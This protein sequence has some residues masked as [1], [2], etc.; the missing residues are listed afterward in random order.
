M[1]DTTAK[2]MRAIATNAVR[3]GWAIF[4]LRP[5]AKVPL[6]RKA[7]G[8]RGVYDGTHDVATVDAWW[9][10]WPDANIGVSCGPA[11]EWSGCWVLDVD[12]HHGGTVTLSALVTAHGPLPKTRVVRTASGGQ[13]WFFRWPKLEEGRTLRNAVGVRGR[14]GERLAGLDVRAAGG[15]V[16]GAGSVAESKVTGS[17]MPYT[18]EV[19]APLADAPEWLLA[20]VAPVPLRA[21]LPP[22]VPRPAV[23]GDELFRRRVAWCRSSLDTCCRNL[24]GLAEGGRNDATNRALMA[25]AGYA[26][27]GYLGSDEVK[28]A[29]RAAA[30]ASG[31]SSREV[32]VIFRG[33]GAWDKGYAT[34]R[35]PELEDRPEYGRPWAPNGGAWQDAPP[36]SD[37]DAP[38]D[39]GEERQEEGGS[40]EGGDESSPSSR[41]D[42]FGP[43]RALIREVY[44]IV[45]RDDT[46][47][48][49]RQQAARTL[50]ESTDAL[51]ALAYRFPGE[52]ESA[53]AALATG[54]GF[55]EHMQRIASAVRKLVEERRKA[56]AAA[57]RTNRQQQD[58]K[59]QGAR[60]GFLVRCDPTVMVRLD[61][62][63][64]MVDGVPE[65]GDPKPTLSNAVLILTDD[66]ACRDRIRFNAFTQLVEIDGVEK[67]DDLDTHVAIALDRAYGLVLP[68]DRVREALS[69]VARKNTYDPLID[70]LDG[71]VW[72]GVNRIGAVF[73]DYF[74]IATPRTV[75]ADG[76]MV[77]DPEL[78]AAIER[79]FF[80]G[81]V[82]RAFK[83]GCKLDTMPVFVGLGG[84][85]KS[86]A[87]AALCPRPEWFSDTPIDLRDK[88][89][90][91]ALDGIWIYEQ[92]ELD[93]LNSGS[94]NRA[95]GFM[96]SAFD[97]YRRPYD[98]TPQRHARRTAMC[99]STNEREF[100]KD[101]RFHP[102]DVRDDGVMNPEGVA[103]LRDQLW[104]EAVAMY[105]SGVAWN[106]DAIE[107][108]RL[109]DHAEK[110]RVVSPWE[111][112]VAAFLAR[113]RT[114]AES[115]ALN[116][117]PHFGI[118]Q[119]M[120]YLAVPAERFGDG[121]IV[122]KVA[123]ILT[124]AGCRKGRPRFEGARRSRWFLP[125]VD[126]AAW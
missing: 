77:E 95:K 35:H 102:L 13:H 9:E 76:E 14:D 96:S 123:A 122:Q 103:L 82:A 20:L 115:G 118:E 45:G 16:V 124:D 46:R 21:V 100:G 38:W 72:D 116:F 17:A 114:A 119:V 104:A 42:L 8:G 52:W 18:V 81:A 117:A 97:R 12:A 25:F 93:T 24:A 15:F 86:R 69:Y 11:P 60:D 84:K 98:R 3:E 23:E 64:R 83:P 7:D 53:R 4:P 74:A 1:N 70:Y 101:R 73:R 94:L 120:T 56:D 111:T 5:A 80:V 85:G 113:E 55:A 37:A 10:R 79:C 40:D 59:Q 110:Y 2:S 62:K 107:H 54:T 87:L 26:A 31:L 28:D 19:D 29:I 33:G 49:E 90:F 27:A 50:A 34:P 67:T 78:A 39:G 22:S 109:M 43:I 66:A 57:R 48:E 32:D 51:A 108:G 112:Q 91:Q 125:G 47:R 88:D 44:A 6:L 58:P 68:T 92:A 30:E 61:R 106:L 75:N 89:R 65:P 71:L 121:R 63:V 36:P 126:P 41:E 105:R 99:G